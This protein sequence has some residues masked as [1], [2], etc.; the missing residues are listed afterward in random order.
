MRRF[1]L[2]EGT[3]SKFWEIEQAD[4]ELNIRWGRIGTAGQSQ[5]KSFAD[6]AKAATGG[7]GPFAKLGRFFG[8][9]ISVRR[10]DAAPNGQ[11]VEATLAH[12]EDRV[13]AG[14]LAGAVTYLSA[15]PAPAQ[16]AIKV[17]L[18][19]ARARVAL[20]NATRQISNTA[21]GQLGQADGDA[22]GGAL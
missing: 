18:D 2:I 10:T 12:A 20:D 15:L 9:F 17:W 1:E 8:S 7:N 19:Q 14:D 11:G 4:T 21:L 22:A 6:A 16:T 3:A 5:T 13:D